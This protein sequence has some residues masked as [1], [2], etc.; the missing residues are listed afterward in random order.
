MKKI[1]PRGGERMKCPKSCEKKKR[2]KRKISWD[3]GGK[4]LSTSMASSTK[5]RTKGEA[6]KKDSSR[7][8]KGQESIKE[9]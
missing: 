8:V 6:D 7:L 9:T 3:T 2:E 1:Q 5:C 4:T